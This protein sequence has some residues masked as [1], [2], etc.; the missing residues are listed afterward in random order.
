[1]EGE[2]VLHVAIEKVDTYEAQP[3]TK[4]NSPSFTQELK[5]IHKIIFHKKLKFKICGSKDIS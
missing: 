4:Q 3:L 5:N 2:S 1:M